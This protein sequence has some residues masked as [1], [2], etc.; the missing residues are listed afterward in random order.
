MYVPLDPLM[1]QVSQLWTE[2]SVEVRRERTL[3]MLETYG[4]T[5][6]LPPA[7]LLEHERL[8]SVLDICSGAGGEALGLEAAGFENAAA[9]ELDAAACKTFKNEPPALADHGER[10]PRH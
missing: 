3:G 2:R 6:S 9:I 10:Y 8:F 4:E 5:T 1:C 7:S